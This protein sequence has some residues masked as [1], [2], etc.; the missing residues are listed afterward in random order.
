MPTPYGF[1][2]L[3]V[4]SVINGIFWVARFMHLYSTPEAGQGTP[5]DD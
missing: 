5:I 4:H 1:L 3:L 2:T